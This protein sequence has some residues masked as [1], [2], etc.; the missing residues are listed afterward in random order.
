MVDL[1]LYGL[2]RA[3]KNKQKVHDENMSQRDS[4]QQPPTPKASALDCSVMLTVE[5]LC[6][7]VLHNHGKWIKSN[8]RQY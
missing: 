6:W 4:D 7:K 2:H 8:T 5:E 3:V 1:I